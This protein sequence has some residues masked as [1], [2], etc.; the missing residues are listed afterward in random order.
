LYRSVL[1][2]GY[3]WNQLVEH[4]A[5]AMLG[6]IYR[7]P[8]PHR[9]YFVATL[10][11]QSVHDL[12]DQGVPVPGDELAAAL[13]AV[14]R[15]QCSLSFGTSATALAKSPGSIGILAIVVGG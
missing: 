5:E 1:G 12:A 14:F 2:D 10:P 15:S 9:Q 7:V 11:N 3:W 13:V 4:C 8:D 6:G